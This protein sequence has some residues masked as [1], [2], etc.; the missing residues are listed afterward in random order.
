[1]ERNLNILMVG[2]EFP[3]FNAGGL[4]V[5]C[6]GLGQALARRGHKVYFLLPLKGE[7]LS[8]NS[9]QFIFAPLDLSEIEVAQAS[10]SSSA[11]TSKEDPTPSSHEASLTDKV[12][13]YREVLDKIEKDLNK[14]FDLIHAHDWL[15]FPAALKLK[16]EKNL[17][18]VLQ[19]HA[20]EFERAG[21]KRGSE[22]VHELESKALNRADRCVAVSN[23]TKDFLVDHY[24]LL[25]GKVDVVYNGLN[26]DRLEVTKPGLEEF[27]SRHSKI[28]LYA[29]RLSLHKGGDWF[30]KAAKE[31]L[32]EDKDVVFVMAGEGEMKGELLELAAELGVLD[33]LY[34]TGFLSPPQL[35]DLYQAADVYVLPSVC[36]PFG[37]TS[38]EAMNFETPT[39]L[40]CQAGAS[41]VLKNVLTVDFWDTRKMA[42]YIINLLKHPPLNQEMAANGSKEARKLTWEKAAENLEKV[43]EKVIG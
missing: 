38:L 35:A 29:G 26:K 6:K 15:T 20:S 4:G 39:I 11:G 42:D 8:S 28:V 21:G 1:M 31:V 24:S 41:E 33:R 10:Y 36:E 7:K 22:L 40:S 3:P 17:P 32:K 16:D 37:I 5:A 23:H 2:W 14:E 19:V 30:L 43:Y 34:L 27:Q 12:F 18:L 13:Q 9:L 25:E